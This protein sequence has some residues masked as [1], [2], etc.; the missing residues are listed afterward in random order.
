M[1]LMNLMKMMKQLFIEAQITFAPK[2]KFEK[3]KHQYNYGYNHHIHVLILN[4]FII[5]KIIN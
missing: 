4:K 3:C 5:Y 1:H 2:Y